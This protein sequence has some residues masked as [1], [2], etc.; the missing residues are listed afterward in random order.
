MIMQTRSKTRTPTPRVF[1]TT[2]TQKEWEE[3]EKI[4]KSRTFVANG[5][6]Y[7]ILS[8]HEYEFYYNGGRS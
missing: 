5:T 8:K 2:Y 4:E 7:R 6:I 1:I 3:K